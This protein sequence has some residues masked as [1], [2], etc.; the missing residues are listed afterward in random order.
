M[1][2][3]VGSESAGD[4]LIFKNLGVLCDGLFVVVVSVI[5]FTID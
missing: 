2:V 5:D 1:E 3:F 4:F